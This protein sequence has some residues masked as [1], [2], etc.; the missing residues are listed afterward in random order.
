MN[1][2][3][4]VVLFNP[5]S[6]ASVTSAAASV[7]ATA[8]ANATG[9]SSGEPEPEIE[10]A[11]PT[12]EP[13]PEPT[14]SA[15]AYVN[16]ALNATLNATLSAEGE[17]EPEGEAHSSVGRLLSEAGRMLSEAVPEPE[18]ELSGWG[19]QLPMWLLQLG[20]MVLWTMTYHAFFNIHRELHNP[21][22]E[23]APL[24]PAS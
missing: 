16:A 24:L 6:H 1:S 14:Q 5:R 22:G 21:Y 18:S 17:A 12:P 19:N 7:A 8:L 2:L 23:A 9:L 3:A 20:C 10:P 13:T 4:C 11:E 15:W